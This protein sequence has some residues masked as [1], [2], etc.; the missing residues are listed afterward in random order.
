MK[1]GIKYFSKFC[2]DY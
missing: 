1:S 2:C